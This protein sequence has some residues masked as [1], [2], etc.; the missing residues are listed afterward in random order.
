MEQNAISFFE[1]F[2]KFFKIKKEFD[3]KMTYSHKYYHTYRVLKW[4]KNIIKKLNLSDNEKELA[5]T[6]AIFH[7]LGRFTQLTRYSKYNDIKTRFDHGKESIDI[8]KQN[9]WFTQNNIKLKEEKAICFAI[10]NHNK[11]KIEK[12][13]DHLSL[14]LAKLIRDADKLAIIEECY[15]FDSFGENKSYGNLSPC[16]KRQFIKHHL[17]NAKD[18]NTK[19]DEICYYIAYIFD[20]NFKVSLKLIKEKYLLEPYFTLLGQTSSK[21]IEIKVRNEINLFLNHQNAY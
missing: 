18:I 8:L 15:Q 9:N 6:V 19:E 16:I 2:C 20:L 14:L 21:Q 11:L 4:M 1:E 10:Y 7:D 5:K 17:L 13:E 12:T 3:M